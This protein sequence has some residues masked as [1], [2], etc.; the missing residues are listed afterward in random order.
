[1]AR[2]HTP[3]YQRYGNQTTPWEN[4]DQRSVL[5][6]FVLEFLNAGDT[7][8]TMAENRGQISDFFTPCKNYG[9]GGKMSSF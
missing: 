3:F 5:P 9:S 8:R 4:P 1:M 2:N 6:E 7:E